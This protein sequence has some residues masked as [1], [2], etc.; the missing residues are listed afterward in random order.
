MHMLSL[1][2]MHF[3]VSNIALTCMEMYLLV[4]DVAHWNSRDIAHMENGPNTEGDA[5][6]RTNPICNTPRLKVFSTHKTRP[7]ALPEV[8]WNHVTEPSSPA[9]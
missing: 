4:R 8:S 7:L 2:E 6:L 9:A 5:E 1:M 3:L